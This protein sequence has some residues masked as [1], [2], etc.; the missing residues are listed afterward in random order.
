MPHLAITCTPNIK[1]D[2]D[3][4]CRTLCSTLISI[5]DEEGKPV[6][7]PGGTRVM[8]FPAAHYAVA[9]GRQDYRFMYLNLRI[10]G[11]RPASVTKD[12]GDKLLAATKHHLEPVI[13]AGPIG[14]TIQIDETPMTWPGPLIMSHEDRHNTLHA[15]FR[16]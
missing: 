9:D 12:T 2:F 8:V 6:Y 11:G 3:A 14:I 5:R 16:K 13:A 10:F 7:P 4:L 15:L 1:T